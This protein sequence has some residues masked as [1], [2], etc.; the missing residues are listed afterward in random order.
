MVD[1]KNF[2]A[3]AATMDAMIARGADIET[4]VNWIMLS[5]YLDRRSIFAHMLPRL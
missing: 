5:Q 1:S 4:R 2:P 3:V